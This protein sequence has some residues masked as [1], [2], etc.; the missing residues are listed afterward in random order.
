M[1]LNNYFFLEYQWGNDFS[2]VILKVYF[3]LVYYD[4]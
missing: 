3:C 2:N 4:V 1:K